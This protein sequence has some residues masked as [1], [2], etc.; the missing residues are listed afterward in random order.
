MAFGKY[1][2]LTPIGDIHDHHAHVVRMCGMGLC[3]GRGGA[4]APAAHRATAQIVS[5][6]HSAWPSTSCVC[7]SILGMD[8]WV[9]LESVWFVVVCGMGWG[10]SGRGG[11][12]VGVGG[13]GVMWGGVNAFILSPLLSQAL[14]SGCAVRP[15]VD[16]T[17]T[18][19]A[20][21]CN[22]VC[23]EPTAW[24]LEYCC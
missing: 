18:R 20:V 9:G 21:K 17:C 8:G 4:S 6:V 3:F 22:I 14:S 10:E 13:G 7:S 2:H 24:H 11:V 1:L 12:C 15:R 23:D 5:A 19:W 16:R